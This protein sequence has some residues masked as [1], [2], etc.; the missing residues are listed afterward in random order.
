MHLTAEQQQELARF[1]VPLRA[2]V[3][4]ELAAGNHIEEIGHTH[5]APPV[6]AYIKLTRRV[7]TC[8]RASGCGRVFY[9]RHNSSYSGEFT[10]AA[11]CFFVLEPPHPPP[12]EPDMDA[13][14]KAHVPEPSLRFQTAHGEAGPSVRVPG[15]PHP[16]AEPPHRK[17]ADRE[18]AQA[19]PPKRALTKT[20][21]PAGWTRLLYFRDKR[22]P[23]AVQ[24]A[25]ERELMVLF[26][27]T[28]QDSRLRF[29]ATAMVVGAPYEFELRF[30]SASDSENCY[31]LR[32]ATSWAEAD[33]AYHDYFRSTSE[34]WFKFWTR[35]LAQAD[36]PEE[37][38]GSESRYQDYCKAA[39]YAQSQLNSVAAVQRVILEGMRQGATF[40]RSHKEGGTRIYWRTGKFI[41]SDYGDYPGTQ[42]FTGEADFLKSLWHFCQF[43]V[44]RNA[45]KQELA[46]LDAWKLIL[47]RMTPG[48]ARI[49]CAPDVRAGQGLTTAPDDRLPE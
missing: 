32:V 15:R 25:L 30:L 5:P 29:D 13:I 37:N 12:H 7:S 39:L 48:L 36:P 24:F 42:E 47:R 43:E 16:A 45:G 9:E 2:L 33:P 21:A 27:G 19:A 40:N 46:E 38:E 1:P 28:M 41:R 31:S 3:E 35:D 20:E 18:P 8:P 22:P 44:T 23:H 6:G 10:D 17:A 14:R 49:T 4:A 11:R 26:T 34:S